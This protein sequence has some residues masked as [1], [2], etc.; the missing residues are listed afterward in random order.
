[1]KSRILHL[2]TLTDQGAC[3][4]QVELFRKRFGESV[5][6]TDTLCIKVAQDFDFSWAARHLLS[7]SVLADYER[8]KA[9]ARADYDRVTVAAL[10]D[11][12]R[13]KAAVLADYRRVKAAVLADYERVKAAAWADY[14]RVTAAVLADYRRVKA[15]AF[16]KGYSV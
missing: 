10:A 6:V 11:Y 5:R 9:A 8:V 15:A 2:K 1:M 7:D 16:A 4:E 12:R 14:D 13:V 3:D